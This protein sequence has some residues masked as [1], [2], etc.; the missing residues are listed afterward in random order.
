MNLYIMPQG[1]A[2]I[3]IPLVAFF[4]I[5]TYIDDLKNKK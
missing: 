5:V 3:I 1:A 4:L 2:A